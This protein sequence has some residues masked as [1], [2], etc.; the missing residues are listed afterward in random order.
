MTRRDLLRAMAG[1]SL[2]RR[3]ARAQAPA[4]A[5]L[6][7]FVDIAK[8]AGVNFHCESSR[9]TQKYLIETMV[10]GVAMFDYDGDGRLDLYFVNGAELE[11][12]MQGR[13]PD[14]SKPQFW[15]RLYRNNGDGMFTDVTE[16]A[17]VRGHSY[18]MGCAVGDYDNDGRPDLYVTNY[19]RN[20]LYHNNGD[21]TFTDVTEKAGVAAGGW[22]ASA[23]FVD[24]DRDG[25]LDLIVSR[26]LDW[27]IHKNP[28]CGDE[29]RNFRA[30]CHPEVFKPV[31]HIVYHNNG[32]GTFTDVTRKAGFGELPGNGLGIDTND[33][34]QDGW[35]DILVANDALPQQ[36]FRNN[37][38]GTFT[39]VGVTTGLSY[40]EDGQ[41]YSGMGVTFED[42]DNDGWPDVFIGNLANQRYA[43]YRNRKGMFEYVTP[44]TGVGAITQLHSAWGLHFVDTDNDG[45]KDLFAAQ[46]HV[47]DNIH[48]TQ[49]SLSYPET[50]LLLRNTGGRFEDIS[51]RS[52]DPFKIPM[53]ARG[54][55]FGDLN[56]D[57][58]IDMAVNCLDG[59]AMI[60]QNKGNANHW[61]L[62]ALVGTVSNRDAI[63]ARVRLVAESGAS[64]YATVGT[65]GSYM[66]ASDKRVHF[67]LGQEKR[68]KLIEIAW[69]SGIVQKLENVAADQILRVEEPKA[70]PAGT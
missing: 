11:E 49:P 21:G 15:N 36:L 61:L 18:G 24:Y 13:M 8:Q 42:Y 4:P 32:D 25:K 48:E 51:K 16:K 44:S 53:V 68:A 46:S 27:D 10:G 67:G 58:F 30:Y 43:I 22:S 33:F 12:S 54:V 65:A 5:A 31:T 28:W 47:M 34:D 6:P 66:S 7:Q 62:L 20:I 69:P 50:L 59:Q 55:A 17:G 29:S 39:E 23:C 3:L 57:G 19:G 70:K 14:K 64:Q 56:N 1:A 35:P 40:D 45:W 41:V 2:A 63:G 52:G 60:L 37:Q 9:T 38:D 26:Y